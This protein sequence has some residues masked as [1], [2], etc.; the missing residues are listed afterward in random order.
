ME[1]TSSSPPAPA[2]PHRLETIFSSP[3]VQ[4]PPSSAVTGSSRASFHQTARSPLPE[5]SLSGAAAAQLAALE[6]SKHA[7][8]FEE[9]AKWF[10]GDDATVVDGASL[11]LEYSNDDFALFVDPAKQIVPDPLRR[12]LPHMRSMAQAILLPAPAPA[13]PPVSSARQS[14]P[15]DCSPSTFSPASKAPDTSLPAFD[16]L[17][18]LA[19]E[20]PFLVNKFASHLSNQLT[21]GGFSGDRNFLVALR[22]VLPE[23]LLRMFEEKLQRD[24][25]LYTLASRGALPREAAVALVKQCLPEGYELS[26]LD[27]IIKFRR[28]PAEQLDTEFGRF[29]ELKRQ[30]KDMGVAVSEALLWQVCHARLLDT[31]ERDAL[32]QQEAYHKL[33]A[34]LRQPRES[35][36]ATLALYSELWTRLK[37]FCTDSYFATRTPQPRLPLPSGTSSSG[38][39]TGTAPSG[40]NGTGRGG[41][42]SNRPRG[43]SG[44]SATG[45]K[46]GNSP[47]PGLRGAGARA[48]AAVA[49]GGATAALAAADAEEDKAAATVAAAGQLPFGGWYRQYGSVENPERDLAEMLLREEANECF[50][51]MKLQFDKATG[52]PHKHGSCPYHNLVTPD[53]DPLAG[54]E[55]RRY[56]AAKARRS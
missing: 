11:L 19:N 39:S 44:P 52:R 29:N 43:G 4:Q 27:N 7:G 3:N 8:R 48:A 21:Q 14:L 10:G 31:A 33:L 18:H 24:Q 37:R 23:R 28:R 30:C 46:R 47:H 5:T 40:G 34:G 55:A 51:C 26:L 41:S 42:G 38:A 9:L 20:T 56:N 1:E 17:R 53:S 32:A 16:W 49:D 25:N 15:G 13:L 12:H 36:D 2:S 6:G 54:I 50:R 45:L 22:G 35:P